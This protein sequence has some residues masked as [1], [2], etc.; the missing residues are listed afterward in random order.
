MKKSALR[1]L[2]IVLALVMILGS[3]YFAI[4]V[5]DTVI[6]DALSRDTGIVNTES[7]IYDEQWLER[8]MQSDM[9]MDLLFSSFRD[10]TGYHVFPDWYGGAYLNNDQK[11]VILVTRLDRELL[12]HI[13]EITGN[14]DIL[15]R[16]VRYSHTELS[17]MMDIVADIV[18]SSELSQNIANELAREYPS[19]AITTVAGGIDSFNNGLV[20]WLSIDESSARASES[21]DDIL[22]KIAHVGINPGIVTFEFHP[23]VSNISEADFEIAV[24]NNMQRPMP[25]QSILSSFGTSSLGFRATWN[26]TQ[27]YVGAAHA[28]PLHGDIFMPGSPPLMGTVLQRL[29]PHNGTVDVAFI[30]VPAG[31]QPDNTVVGTGRR[32]TATAVEPQ[33]QGQAIIVAGL[34]NHSVQNIQAVS[35][36]GD[37]INPV[38]G[39]ITRT[40]DTFAFHIQPQPV[41]SGWSGGIIIDLNNNVLGIVKGGDV[42]SPTVVL[43]HAIKATNIVAH[44]FSPF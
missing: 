44:G 20:I 8:V 16:Q 28:M 18:S 39:T 11:N 23:P 12:H 36:W 15:L 27:G 4:A 40:R 30:G 29:H 21:V 10:Y 3:V 32:H 25:G 9:E 1:V 26:G 13:W 33:R 5:E 43:R 42:N 24:P 38:D 35:S 31:I 2:L 22:A 41:G 7:R 19:E 6:R 34:S 14:H 17:R 37:F